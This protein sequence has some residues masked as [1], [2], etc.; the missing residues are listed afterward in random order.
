MRIARKRFLVSGIGLVLLSCLLMPRGVPLAQERVGTGAPRVGQKAPDFT[1]PD[2]TGKLVRLS[3][4]LVSP[5]PRGGE[6]HRQ[7]RWL[8]VIFY[9]GYW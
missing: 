5:V 6:V 8:V 7:T 1:L 3:D 2:A 9:R 4:L